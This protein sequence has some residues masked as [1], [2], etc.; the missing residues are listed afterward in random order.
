MATT[1][2]RRRRSALRFSKTQSPNVLTMVK[3][4]GIPVTLYDTAMNMSAYGQPQLMGDLFGDIMGAVVGKD[5]W[6]ARPDWMKK[7]QVKPDPAKIFSQAVKAVPPRQVGNVV[8]QAGNY[9]LDMF[10]KTPVGN[11][12]I[13]PETAEGI[14]GNYP[15]YLTTKD[16]FSSVPMW[17][18]LIGGAGI[19]FAFMRHGK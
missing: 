15:A 1:Y 14:Y 2:P 4:S 7:I 6:N 18:Y 10:Y 11:M 19:L 5:N 16:V 3:G 9:G 13:T 12:P 17:V 8:R